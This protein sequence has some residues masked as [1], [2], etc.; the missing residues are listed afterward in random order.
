MT[1]KINVKRTSQF[2]SIAFI[3]MLLNTLV[4]LL[5]LGTVS[6]TYSYPG[7]LISTFFFLGATALLLFNTKFKS[8]VGA[9]VFL[10]PLLPEII[11]Y[12]FV[13]PEMFGVFALLAPAVAIYFEKETHILV[14]GSFLFVG[15]LVFEFSKLDLLGTEWTLSYSNYL[16]YG[17]V[18]F[19]SAYFL[20]SSRRIVKQLNS[21]QE[22]SLDL[23]NYITW[24]KETL[25][26]NLK[27]RVKISD[28]DE[29]FDSIMQPID[30]I[31]P[32]LSTHTKLASESRIGLVQLYAVNGAPVLECSNVLL[33]LSNLEEQALRN[34]LEKEEYTLLFMNE[35]FSQFSVMPNA[36][37]NKWQ[38]SRSKSAAI[39]PLTLRLQ[40][41][42]EP[43]IVNIPQPSLGERILSAFDLNTHKPK[44]EESF[45]FAT[46]DVVI[47][48]DDIPAEYQTE[49][50]EETLFELD[51]SQETEST[52]ASSLFSHSVTGN[53]VEP[54][55]KFQ[56]ETQEEITL[57][58]AVP[59]NEDT[60]SLSEEN[61]ELSKKVEPALTQDEDW[62]AKRT[63]NPSGGRSLTRIRKIPK[64]GGSKDFQWNVPS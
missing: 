45:D 57:Q 10:I 56:E 48:F 27:L 4:N 25:P 2:G 18:G 9:P 39:R 50:K 19:W 11:N 20:L 34:A 23:G 1:N 12:F 53:G 28:D 51:Q 14:K 3:L 46:A 6:H 36:L 41:S 47:G 60:I 55:E 17:A 61:T 13:H 64:E 15:M 62:R 37:A 58:T 16:Q 59:L 40:D 43:V 7:V 32:V 33:T 26:N 63:F 31:I 42:S 21:K 38:K 49:E 29:L 54:Q 22:R 5:I 8:L 35:E 24:I 44:N 52:P 30:D